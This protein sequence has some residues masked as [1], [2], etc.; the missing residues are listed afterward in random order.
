MGSSQLF[1]SVLCL[2]II[3]FSSTNIAVARS[4][5]GPA[6]QDSKTTTNTTI[7]TTGTS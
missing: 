2:I 3:T 1:P 4:Y 7:P 5:F 6:V